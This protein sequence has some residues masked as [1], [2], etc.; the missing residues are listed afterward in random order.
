MPVFR[1]GLPEPFFTWLPWAVRDWLV[2]VAVLAVSGLLVWFLLGLVRSGPVAAAERI[3]RTVAGA[4]GDLIYLS[5]RRVMAL[6][7]LAVKES[8]RNR[9]VVVFAVF[10][11]LLMGGGWFLDPATDNPARLYL[12]FV[13]TV[14]SYL[15]LLLALLLSAF[16]LP[17]DLRSRTLHTIVTKPVRPSEIILGRILGFTVIGTLL[18]AGM[19]VVSWVFVHRGLNHAHE[20]GTL[21][22]NEG[23]AWQHQGRTD[24][25]HGHRH[26]VFIGED[27]TGVTDWA[28]GHWH[29]VTGRRVEGSSDGEEEWVYELGP[30]Q[31][32]LVARVPVFGEL[33]FRDRAGQPTAE[34]INV[35]HE[36]TY[37]TFIE[38]ASLAAAIWTFEGITPDRFPEDRFPDGLPLEMT[39]GVFRTHMGDI[40]RGIGGSLSVRN[41]RTDRMVTARVF[42]AREYVTD[43]QYIPRTLRD[44][45]TDEE[46]DLFEDLSD[47]GTLEIWLQCL[48]SGQ[49]FGAGVG[50]L[51][52]RA[53][54]ASFAMN[55]AKG[56]FGIWM[57]MLLI[58]SFG[59]MFSTFLSGPVAALATVGA[60][61]AGFFRPFLFDLANREV[62][63]GGP[64]ESLRR[65]ITQENVMAE[66]EP[67][68]VTGVVD[69]L[70]YGAESFLWSVANVIPAFLSFSSASFVSHGFDVPPD[71]L[72]ARAVTTLG[73]LLMLFIFGYLFLKTREVAK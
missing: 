33:R 25:T 59:V 30:P 27:G 14:P 35:G 51:Y 67:G 10:I 69:R 48:P 19:G 18:L 58:I 40:E 22:R 34:G 43:V 55:L 5:P 63:G 1:D 31:D 6:T 21:E 28:H 57:Q 7:W 42:T 39:L 68:L 24:R 17:G 54:D 60:M 37:R 15:V 73:F 32:M 56:Y 13:L 12:D 47:N 8:I 23:D 64:F 65:L 16:S 4:V 3:G 36:S 11:L 38:G 61:L 26:D 45:Q 50:D 41:P 29:H 20:V 72:L 49:Y 62:Y 66:P 44:P 46:L 53:G 70:D 71:W 2:V 52:F 9:V